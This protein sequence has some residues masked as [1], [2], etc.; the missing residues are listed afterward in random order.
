MGSQSS[1]SLQLFHHRCYIRGNTN[2]AEET[3]QYPGADRYDL[4]RGEGRNLLSKILMY[5]STVVCPCF[6]ALGAATFFRILRQKFH[7]WK[8]IISRNNFQRNDRL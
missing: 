1:R 5:C 6:V 3:S 8:F 4:Y 7:T 2:V